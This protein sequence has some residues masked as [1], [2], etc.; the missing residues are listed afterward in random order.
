MGHGGGGGGHGGGGG[1]GGGGHMGGG[2]GGGYGGG[3]YGGG[4]GG[5]GNYALASGGGYGAINGPVYA[6]DTDSE[7]EFATYDPDSEYEELEDE[8]DGY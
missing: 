2:Y 3:G 4:Y 7:E 5:Y 6:T 1:M 8:L